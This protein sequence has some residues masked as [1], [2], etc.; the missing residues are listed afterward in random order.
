MGEELAPEERRVR[1]VFEKPPDQIGHAGKDVADGKINP[2]RDP[3][4]DQGILERLRHP[5]QKVN[6]S[7]RQS[8]VFPKGA[9]GMGHAPEIVGGNEGNHRIPGAAKSVHETFKVRVRL[10]LSLKDRNGPVV[11]PGQGHFLIP[12]GPFHQP[13][14]ELQSPS[15]SPGEKL[16]KIPPVSER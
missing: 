1:G 3:N 11:L 12:V 10:F 9:D 15:P 5:V 8:S 7:R 14:G 4:T 16:Q 13:H 6:F 2:D